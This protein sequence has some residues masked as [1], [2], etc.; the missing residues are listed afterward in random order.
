LKGIKI[1]IIHVKEKLNDGPDIGETILAQ[2]R[3]YE[4]RHQLGCEFIKAEAG[5]SV[6]L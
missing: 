5:Q 3:G 6:Y 2:L 4:A 1:V